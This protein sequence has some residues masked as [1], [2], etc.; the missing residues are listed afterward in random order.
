MGSR[1]GGLNAGGGTEAKRGNSQ[2]TQIRKGSW[3]EGGKM[4]AWNGLT[5][6]VLDQGRTGVTIGMGSKCMGGTRGG[7]GLTWG[8]G[9]G[10][11]QCIGR[12][13]GKILNNSTIRRKTT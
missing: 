2:G 7:R 5:V 6:K 13:P 4:K 3:S 12:L 11:L 8:T 1:K 10:G 9:D